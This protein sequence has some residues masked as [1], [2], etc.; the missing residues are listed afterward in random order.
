LAAIGR[1]NLIDD[2]DQTGFSCTIGSEQP[3]HGL[4]WHGDA[5]ILQG[6][7]L[8]IVLKNV[9]GFDG[10]HTRVLLFTST[11]LRTFVQSAPLELI[12]GNKL[13]LDGRA[14]AHMV[15]AW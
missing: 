15:V 10:I 7:M 1:R 12:N 3:E 4:C 8:G 11:I 14:A 2:A 9:F 13:A 6:L 5:Y